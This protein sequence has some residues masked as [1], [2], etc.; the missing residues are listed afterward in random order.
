LN[1]PL[2]VSDLSLVLAVAAIVILVTSELLYASPNYASRIPLDKRLLRLIGV[3]CG[4]GFIVTVALRFVGM[5]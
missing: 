5:T 2:T 1:F 3:G 4:A